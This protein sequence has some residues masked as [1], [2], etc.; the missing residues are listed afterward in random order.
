MDIGITLHQK[1][2]YEHRQP[3]LV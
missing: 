3:R 2:A 1:C